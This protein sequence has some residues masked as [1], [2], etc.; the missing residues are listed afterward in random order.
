LRRLLKVPMDRLCDQVVRLDDLLGAPARAL[1]RELCEAGNREERIGI[2]EHA[3]APL[4][5]ARPLDRRIVGAIEM[6]RNRPD[7]DIVAIADCVGWSRKHL[8]DRMRD[9]V[10]VG[11]R[12][13]RRLLRF[14]KLT[15][16][17]SARPVTDWASCALDAGYCDQSHLIREFREFAG[18]TPSEFAVRILFDGG[19]LVER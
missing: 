7:L 16:R 10:G 6:L 3:L 1:G 15:R 14:Q 9:T 18:I 12:T 5:H 17:I 8:A 4:T 13:F 2:L 19:G 11:P